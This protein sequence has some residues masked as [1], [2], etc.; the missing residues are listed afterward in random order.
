M[1]GR[2][3]VRSRGDMSG[4]YAICRYGWTDMC[5]FLGGVGV[6]AFV[7]LKMCAVQY[8]YC[9]SVLYNEVIKSVNDNY[10][11]KTTG[12]MCSDKKKMSQT[13]YLYVNPSTCDECDLSGVTT[14]LFTKAHTKTC[15]KR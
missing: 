1:H 15:S 14:N 7:H 12:R 13:R 5:F 3:E 8:N 2:M 11:R 6:C 4:R 9:N 10:K